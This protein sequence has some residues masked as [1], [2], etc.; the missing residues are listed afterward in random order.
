MSRTLSKILVICALVVVV[1]LMVVG[2]TLAAYFSINS[3][4]KI[5]SYVVDD[6]YAVKADGE[7]DENG[8]EFFAGYSYAGKFL[9]KSTLDTQKLSK[10]ALNMMKKLTNLRVGSE[11]Q[12]LNMQLLQHKALL[13]LKQKTPWM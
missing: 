13:N 5:A 10:S 11:E 9:E 2:T 7:K 3:T 6:N 4:V 8:E 12:R 1:P